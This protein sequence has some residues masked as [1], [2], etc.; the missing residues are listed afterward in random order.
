MS[1]KNLMNS[2]ILKQ[3]FVHHTFP[4]KTTVHFGQFTPQSTPKSVTLF[5]I[6][7]EVSDNQRKTQ[8]R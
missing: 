2:T 7:R 5:K 3:K 8:I 4:H 6:P 1:Y